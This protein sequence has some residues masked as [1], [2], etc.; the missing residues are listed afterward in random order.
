MITCRKE[1]QRRFC[2]SLKW[3]QDPC[4]SR[5]QSALRLAALYSCQTL[6]KYCL[7]LHLGAPI[8]LLHVDML[9]L[10]KPRKKDYDGQFILRG[11]N[12]I[13]RECEFKAKFTINSWIIIR[14]KE[15]NLKPNSNWWLSY[16]RDQ[17]GNDL[18]RNQR[19]LCRVCCS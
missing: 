9:D 16:L 7:A 1:F 13:Y 6:L 2:R 18:F 4:W 12:Y 5:S 3:F 19:C 8:S 15:L 10:S 17:F 11:N 14:V